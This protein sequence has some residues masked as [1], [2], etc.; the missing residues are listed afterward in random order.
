[1]KNIKYLFQF[2]LIIFFVATSSSNLESNEYKIDNDHSFITF[3]IGHFNVGYVLGRFN[4]FGGHIIYNKEHIENASV[5][6]KID[7]ISI[8]TGVA[9]RDFHLRTAEFLDI[10][11]FP[12]ITFVSNKIELDKDNKHFL[13]TGKLKIKNKE[14]DISIKAKESGKTIDP[15]GKERVAFMGTTVLNRFDFGIDFDGRLKDNS[16]MI[17]ENIDVL[18]YLEAIKMEKKK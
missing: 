5:A 18:I 3:K 4:T 8:D 14:K 10:F 13:I 9:K 7:T 11:Q 1:M 15:Y 16:P 12:E 17:D 6:V 2:I